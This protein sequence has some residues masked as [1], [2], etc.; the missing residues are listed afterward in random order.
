MFSLSGVFNRLVGEG[1][2]EFTG[3][4]ARTVVPTILF[5]GMLYFRGK[6]LFRSLSLNQIGLFALRVFLTV[7]DFF[8]F[9]Y[10][11]TRMELGITLVLFYTAYLIVSF[12]YTI[13]DPEEDVKLLD[14]LSLI[15]AIIGTL[16]A[17]E[18]MK[19]NFNEG[20]IRL[21]EYDL[22]SISFL[23]LIAIFITGT[24]FALNTAFSRPLTQKY[25]S[26]FVNFVTYFFSSLITIPIFVFTFSFGIE[27]IDFNEI[28]P[29]LVGFILVG[30][31]TFFTFWLTLQG[32]KM[33]K[34]SVASLI[35]LSEIIFT[36]IIGA[37]LYNEPITLPIIIGSAL[38]IV[39]LALPNLREIFKDK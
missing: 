7:I 8:T 16:I 19:F 38:V 21:V 6:K 31:S 23:P 18:I 29:V 9:F 24:S 10:A 25:D 36:F 15:L 3:M 32:Y 17:F 11:V 2:G 22:S 12:L 34:V 26:S 4:L 28:V 33:V 1:A 13:I 30:T 20:I 37:I 27:Q 5:G 39:A 35:L 14:L